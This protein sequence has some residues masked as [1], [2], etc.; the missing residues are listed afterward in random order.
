MNF[1]YL[2]IILFNMHQVFYNTE[3]TGTTETVW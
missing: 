3:L 2:N 1:I